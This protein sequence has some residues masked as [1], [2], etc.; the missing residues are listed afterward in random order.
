MMRTPTKI[1]RMRELENDARR[2]QLKMD[3]TENEWAA[4]LAEVINT[5]EWRADCDTRGLVY[6]PT[7]R[8]NLC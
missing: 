1:K 7:F 5:R 2:L 8:D 6:N 4:L 3:R